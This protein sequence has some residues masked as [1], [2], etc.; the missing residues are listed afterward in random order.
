MGS[1]LRSLTLTLLLALTFWKDAE[2]CPH[3]PPFPC[4]VGCPGHSNFRGSDT[5]VVL[6]APNLGREEP[7]LPHHLKVTRLGE[8]ERPGG[9]MGRGCWACPCLLPLEVLDVSKPKCKQDNTALYHFG[10]SRADWRHPEL[11]WDVGTF[12]L[13][14]PGFRRSLCSH[15][16]IY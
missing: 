10:R 14:A 5:S 11:P 9:L 1:A 8:Q 13:G 3:V 7:H 2:L 15:K 16:K 4:C 6:M 12:S